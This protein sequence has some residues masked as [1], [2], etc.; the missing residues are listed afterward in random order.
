MD[1]KKIQDEV[2]RVFVDAFGN[3]S[4]RERHN[5]ILNE[6]IEL[7]RTDVPPY[8]RNVF[9]KKI[10]IFNIKINSLNYIKQD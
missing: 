9:F 8:K 3:S 10:N 4:L 5:D 7:T 1:S 2:N 6:A